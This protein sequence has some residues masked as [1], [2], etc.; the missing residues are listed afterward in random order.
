MFRNCENSHT[1]EITFYSNDTHPLI[2]HSTDKKCTFLCCYTS[3]L[4]PEK[5]FV[6]GN[7]MSKYAIGEVL[8]QKHENGLNHTV[9][10]LQTLDNAEHNHA[11]H[12]RVTSLRRYNQVFSRSPT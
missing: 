8:D 12:G 2:R 7:E 9:Y 4:E 11:A 3:Y 1:T 10:T 5:K 6:V